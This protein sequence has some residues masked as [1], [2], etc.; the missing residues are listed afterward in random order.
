M[1]WY[2]QWAPYVPVAQRR[3]KAEQAAKRLVTKGKKLAPINIPGRAIASTFWGKAWCDHIEEYCDES[4]RLPRGRTY[5]RNGSIVDLQITKGQITALVSGSSLYSI[6]VTITNL[7]KQHWKTI[8]SDCAKS[9]HSLIDLM[10]GK[11]SQEIIARLTDPVNGLFPKV[12]QIKLSC[13]CPDGA[14]LCKHLAAVLYGVGH[15]LDSS[16]ELLFL[17][18][19]VKQT[20]LISNSMANQNLGQTIGL[21]KDSSIASEDLGDIFGID[22]ASP[23][24][25]PKAKK[26]TRKKAQPVIEKVSAD[27]PKKVTPRKVT[28]RKVTP[29][30]VTPKKVTPKK[31]TPR[32]VTPKKATPKKVTPKKVTPRKVTPRKV[33]P[34]RTAVPKKAIVKKTDSNPALKT[35]LESDYPSSGKGRPKKT[36][37]PTKPKEFRIT[38]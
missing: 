31:V 4:N 5:A 18:R 26:A 28:P 27:A 3:R 14:Y 10:R 8:C 25:T 32:K 17:L 24:E 35:I 2:R 12:N 22:L 19:G 15:R 34:K 13:N 23:A 7:E 38:L 37:K 29:K 20:N 1:S 21:Q 9:I 11:L 16:P 30:K 6:R 33:T 36:S